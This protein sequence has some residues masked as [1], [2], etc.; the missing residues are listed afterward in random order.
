MITSIGSLL[1]KGNV[2]H[3][4]VIFFNFTL[5]NDSLNNV[6]LYTTCCITVD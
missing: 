5:L 6:I 2:L 1:K 3:I 4:P